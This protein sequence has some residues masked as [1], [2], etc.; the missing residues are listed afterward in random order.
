MAHATGVRRF[1]NR[2]KRKVC[3]KP[4]PYHFTFR[5]SGNGNIPE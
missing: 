5:V 1:D 3:C 4:D 2:P